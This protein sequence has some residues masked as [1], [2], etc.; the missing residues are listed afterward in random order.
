MTDTSKYKFNHSM[1]GVKGV[2]PLFSYQIFFAD[3]WGD[4]KA[5]IKFYEYLGMSLMKKFEFP[6]YK[7]DIYFL[8]YGDHLTLSMSLH[9]PQC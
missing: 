9:R 5:S 1:L 3:N 6:D 2:C 7:L 4:P 8:A